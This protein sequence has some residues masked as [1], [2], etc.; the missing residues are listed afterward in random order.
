M[1][2]DQ[3]PSFDIPPTVLEETI[4]EPSVLAET[5][6]T[7]QQPAKPVVQVKKFLNVCSF[8]TWTLG[9]WADFARNTRYPQAKKVEE[10]KVIVDWH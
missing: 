7:P 2:F 10:E 1:S 8:F 6:P 4:P 5:T 9:G 3:P